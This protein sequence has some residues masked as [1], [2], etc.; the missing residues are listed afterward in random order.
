MENYIVEIK[1]KINRNQKIED[2][3][4]KILF[5]AEQYLNKYCINN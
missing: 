5:N 3:T 1:E 2:K 4:N